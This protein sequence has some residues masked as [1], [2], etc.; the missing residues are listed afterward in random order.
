MTS[1]LAR[2]E[3]SALVHEA[4]RAPN[5]HN[6]QPA[7]WRFDDDGSVILFRA[8]DRAIPVADP[9]GHDLQA[10]LGA[11]VEGMAIALSTRG[12]SLGVPEA[13]RTAVAPGC[14]PV[15]R[16]QIDRVPG[17]PAD[18]LAPWVLRRRSFR[19]RFFRGNPDDA[20]ALAALES[21]DA[22][23][24]VGSDALRDLA[25]LHDRAT[26]TFESRPDY[27]AELWS[28][29]RLSPRD[30][31]YRRDGLNADCLALSAPERWAAARLLVPK[32]FALLA[33]MGVA[34]HLVS[35]AAKVRSA[36]AAIAFCPRRDATPFDVGRRMYRLWLEITAA[37]FYLAPMSASADD[38]PSRATLEQECRVPPDRRIANVFRVGRIEESKVAQ[39]PR[40]PVAE[41]LV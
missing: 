39:S 37:G 6:I 20:R 22:R 35:E 41:L 31:R 5:V 26:W 23:L 27:H 36:A 32:R 19:G 2:A 18:P 11:A 1:A 12:L 28:W 24:I 21:P 15:V 9:T 30:P 7:R 8:L 16:A 17:F 10:S 3:Q 4:A 14:E 33:R 25:A 38:A 34:R 29:L 40:L 13:E